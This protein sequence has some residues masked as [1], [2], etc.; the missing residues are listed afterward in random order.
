MIAAKRVYREM[1][2]RKHNIHHSGIE[3]ATRKYHR[4]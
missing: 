1:M 4:D 2:K 3:E